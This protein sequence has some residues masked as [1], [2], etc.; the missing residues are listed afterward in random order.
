VYSACAGLG[1][2]AGRLVTG[3]ISGSIRRRVV[4]LFGVV[5]LVVSAT[6]SVRAVAGADTLRVLV[7]D[8]DG[9]RAPGIDVLVEA[10]R[11]LPDV[12]LT[13]VAPADDQSGTGDTTTVD[14]STVTTERARTASGRPAI[15]VNG[16][17][18]DAVLWAL[19]GGIGE[20]PDVVVSGSARRRRGSPCARGTRAAGRGGLVRSRRPRL[21]HDRRGHARAGQ[22]VQ[23]RR[24]LIVTW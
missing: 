23:R 21:R 7:T 5:A 20:R 14:L 11:T 24:A 19:G 4:I 15:A 9:V 13:V 12:E 6:V 3:R 2:F 22:Q 1:A 16:Y 18:A 8:D 17:P 10:L